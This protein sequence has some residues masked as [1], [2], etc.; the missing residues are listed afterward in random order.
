MPSGKRP[1]VRE[2]LRDFLGAE[3]AGG[4]A[5]LAAAAAAMVW[6]NLFE[7]SYSEIW[8]T[9]FHL[10]IR[11]VTSTFD[12]RHVINDGLMVVFF[13][14]V[15]LEIKRELVVGELRDRRAAVVPVVAAAG[16][17]IG[18]ALVYLA[19]NPTSP[20]SR[21]WG[22]PMATDIAFALGVLAV[23]GRRAPPGTKLFL[24]TLAIVD[25][26]GAIVVIAV[27]Y[28][29]ELAVVGL[30]V[31]AAG[32]LII[33]VMRRY[34]VRAPWAYII[35]GLIIWGGTAASGVHPT[36]AGVALGL[37]TPAR[38]IRGRAVLEELQER[39]HP[40]SSLLVVPLFALANAGIS[41][42]P[43]ELWQAVRSP[44]FGGVAAGL[45]AG[46]TLGI[47]LATVVVVRLTRARL[48][49]GMRMRDVAAVGALGGVGFT[50]AIFITDLAFVDQSF[51]DSAKAG[52]LLG[53]IGGAL[54]GTTIL[55][56]TN[57]R[58]RARV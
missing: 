34:A 55:T 52:V 57:R 2:A 14:V 32:V 36:I 28:T 51:A 30:A 3:A 53:S 46:K 33:V 48:Q 10:A 5:L 27:A 31:A 50:V 7:A 39:L 6:A 4:V 25:D 56:V 38:P 20:A 18:P 35:P 1:R 8:E 19:F 43:G 15:G 11:G 45:V 42:D 54:V 26:I 17:M 29:A 9:E 40:V 12:L 44:V 41:V 13:L 37:A 47:T 16:G 21:G 58:R 24:L 49:G 22:I 23:A